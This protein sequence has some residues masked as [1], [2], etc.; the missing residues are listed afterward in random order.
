MIDNFNRPI[1]TNI[2]L[3]L[4]ILLSIVNVVFGMLGVIAIFGVRDDDAWIFY[5]NTA[6]LGWEQLKITGFILIII[7]IVMFW[8]VPL[9]L[10]NNTQQADSYL[11]IA[12][13]HVS[14]Y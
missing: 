2:I 4:A 7:G 8:S 13:Y 1:Y 10:T 12:F 14:K 11:V 3:G 9:Y 5:Q 6:I